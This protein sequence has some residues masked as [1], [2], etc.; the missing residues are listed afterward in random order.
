MTKIASIDF[1]N[2]MSLKDCLISKTILVVDTKG[3][4]VLFICNY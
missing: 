3:S 4:K 2:R 1:G